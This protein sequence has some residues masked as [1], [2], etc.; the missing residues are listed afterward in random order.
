[1]HSLYFNNLNLSLIIILIARIYEVVW[2]VLV[3]FFKKINKSKSW[4]AIQIYVVKYN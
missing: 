2:F 4:L 3:V 1:M